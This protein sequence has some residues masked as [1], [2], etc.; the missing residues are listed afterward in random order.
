M[1]AQLTSAL[2]N[3]NPTC[4]SDSKEKPEQ[5]MAELNANALLNGA[6]HDE[7][8]ETQSPKQANQDHKGAPGAFWPHTKSVAGSVICSESSHRIAIASDMV[9]A[10][11][12]LSEEAASFFRS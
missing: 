9:F 5:E 3:A 2:I 1:T 4:I 10:I 7:P 11:S 12:E 6:A 8:D